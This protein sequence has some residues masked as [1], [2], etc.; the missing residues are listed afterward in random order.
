MLKPLRSLLDTF[1]GPS[2][3]IQK[4]QDKHLDYSA[5]QQK[6]EKNKDSSRIK[7]VGVLYEALEFNYITDGH[8]KLPLQYPLV[9]V[10]TLLPV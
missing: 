9:P 4:R 10:V 5:S 7:N 6:A 8:Y 2:R 1:L 3:L